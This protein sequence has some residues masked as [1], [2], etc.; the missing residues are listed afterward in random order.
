[1]IFD[2]DRK[3]QTINLETYKTQIFYTNED[4]GDSSIDKIDAWNLEVSYIKTL[5]NKQPILVLDFKENREFLLMH[6]FKFNIYINDILITEIQP[7]KGTKVIEF[8]DKLETKINSI[9]IENLYFYQNKWKNYKNI[10]TIINSEN[11]NKINYQS[12]SSI[13]KIKIPFINTFLI[14]KNTFYHYKKYFNIY[15][16]WNEIQNIENQKAI[17]YIKIILDKPQDNINKLLKNKKI[18]NKYLIDS[19]KFFLDNKISSIKNGI[20][21]S[22]KIFNNIKENEITYILEINDLLKTDEKNILIEKSEDIQSYKTL[23]IPYK[24]N[25]ILNNVLQLNL[26]NYTINFLKSTNLKDS[27]NS[28]KK[29]IRKIKI[30]S[31]DSLLDFSEE[32]FKYQ[33]EIRELNRII[34]NTFVLEDF[35]IEPKKK[36]DL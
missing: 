33:I 20:N 27:R 17:A 13:D 34:K 30:E 16:D 28:Y 11:E 4:F 3:T 10:I 7:S 26:K 19:S 8:N 21:L 31:F 15:V 29:T 18:I 23:K 32:N 2:L 36:E 22:N 25:G 14:S 6:Q 9:K 5:Y 24:F 35:W 1:M 12:I